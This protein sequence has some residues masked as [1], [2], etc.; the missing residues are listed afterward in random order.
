MGGRR[1]AN[2][3]KLDVLLW[4]Y[5]HSCFWCSEGFEREQGHGPRSPSVDEL[6]P[7]ARGGFCVLPNQVPA[8]RLCNMRRGCTIA[9]R[10]AVNRH[11]AMLKEFGLLEA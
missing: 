5:D 9:P 8:H 11:H 4:L 10:A 6:R 7:R 2:R 1:S 3:R